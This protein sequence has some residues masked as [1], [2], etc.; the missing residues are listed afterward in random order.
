MDKLE[1]IIKNGERILTSTVDRSMI[2]SFVVD[3]LEMMK[4]QHV[5]ICNMNIQLNRI[6]DAER[7][8]ASLSRE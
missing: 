8:R 6:K 3:A 1:R 2:D 4:E 5:K 7:W